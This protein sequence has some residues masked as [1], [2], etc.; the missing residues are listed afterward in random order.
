MTG[1]S[2]RIYH[3]VKKRSNAQLVVLKPYLRIDAKL[4]DA[5]LRVDD[6]V[7]FDL[8]E[9]YS[10]VYHRFLALDRADRP[11]IR[12]QL[13]GPISFGFNITGSSLWSALVAQ[14]TE[15]PACRGKNIG[16]DPITGIEACAMQTLTA[17]K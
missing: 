10:A 16:H 12:G 15:W 8:R 13:E 4:E 9:A 5:L 14:S 2:A 11:A 17:E 3:G 6:P 7:M 1:G